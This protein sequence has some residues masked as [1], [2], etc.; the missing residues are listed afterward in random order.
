MPLLRAACAILRAASANRPSKYTRDAPSSISL[1]RC[2]EI[3]EGSSGA[4]GVCMQVLVPP[5]HSPILKAGSTVPTSTSYAGSAAY[6]DA[7]T[8][9]TAAEV[10]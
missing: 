9:D 4:A 7:S 2:S 3:S 1:M 10:T 5:A 8:I 6:L